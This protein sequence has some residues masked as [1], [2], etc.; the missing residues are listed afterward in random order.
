VW[1]KEDEKEGYKPIASVC[2]MTL[3]HEHA[4]FL[5]ESFFDFVLSVMDSET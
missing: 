2:H 4:L 1:V 5:Q 3:C